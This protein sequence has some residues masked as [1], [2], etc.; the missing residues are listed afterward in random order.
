VLVAQGVWLSVALLAI[1][2][3]FGATFP[4]IV[5]HARSFIPAHLAGRGV[6]LLNLFGI[7]GVGIMQFGSGPLHAAVS[8]QSGSQAAYATLFA[9]FG[10]AIVFGV[11]IYLFSRDKSA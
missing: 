9:F 4:V 2:G 1:I 7:G 3:L 11:V 5:A 6:T 10:L 8:A